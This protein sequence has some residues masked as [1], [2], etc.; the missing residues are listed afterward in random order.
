MIATIKN[1]KLSNW[2]MYLFGNDFITWQPEEGKVPSAW[3]RFWTKVF[4]NCK[5][6]RQH[7]QNK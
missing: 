2:K 1:P 5:W 6:E 4:F 3:V 7:E